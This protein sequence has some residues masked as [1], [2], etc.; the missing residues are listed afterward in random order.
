MVVLC[1]AL[2]EQLF[3]KLRVLRSSHPPGLSALRLRHGLGKPGSSQI[4]YIQKEYPKGRLI[5]LVV[6][7]SHERAWSSLAENTVVY[8]K[9]L[10]E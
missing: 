9:I 7:F 1:L 3:Q 4:F 6:H 5:V 2:Q 10:S 8:A